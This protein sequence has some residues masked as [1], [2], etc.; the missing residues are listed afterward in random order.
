MPATTDRLIEL[1]LFA[2][3]FVLFCFVLFCFVSFYFIYQTIARVYLLHRVCNHI[4][5]M[6]RDRKIYQL[7]NTASE[8]LEH[9]QIFTFYFVLSCLVVIWFNMKTTFKQWSNNST[10]LE[11]FV[12]TDKC[13]VLE[14][15]LS[16]YSSVVQFNYPKRYFVYFSH[17]FIQ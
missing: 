6:K 2:V 11:R 3:C 4:T 8:Q 17:K 16:F 1:L 15:L 7:R 12:W 9:L 14:C 13:R 5:G 10:Q